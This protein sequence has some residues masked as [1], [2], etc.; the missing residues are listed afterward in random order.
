MVS[1]GDEA[2]VRTR[3]AAGCEGLRCTLRT[4]RL[5]FPFSPAQTVDFLG[6]FHGPWAR[7]LAGLDGPGRASLR[8]ELAELFRRNNRAPGPEST[9]LAA[10]YREVTAIR[11]VGTR[12]TPGA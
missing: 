7:V 4:A 12:G 11:S 8:G 3:L 10:D 2:M 5:H 6:Q 1:W 9:E